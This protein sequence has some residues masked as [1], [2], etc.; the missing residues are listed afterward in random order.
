M[1][2]GL[3]ASSIRALV[4]RCG[5]GGGGGL[6]RPLRTPESVT[7][8]ERAA[9]AAQR[10]FD[11]LPE[12]CCFDGSRYRDEF[13]DVLRE[14]PY[15][16]RWGKGSK[17]LVFTNLPSDLNLVC[18]LCHV[19]VILPCD[20]LMA[21]G[22]PATHLQHPALLP[23]RFMAEYLASENACIASETSDVAAHAL[24]ISQVLQ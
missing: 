21:L 8:A 4:E 11:E 1:G 7:S 23:G 17:A 15:V 5:A 18:E 24:M 2:T 10:T 22:R 13:G 9:V 20:G 14:H 3:Q 19:C 12:G 6:T 16:D